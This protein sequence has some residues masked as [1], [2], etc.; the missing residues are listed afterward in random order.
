MRIPLAR[1]G[2]PFI[3]AS[4]FVTI[5]FTITGLRVISYLSLALTTFI[6]AFFRDP[7]REIPEDGIVSPADG[8]VIKVERCREGRILKAEAQKVSIFMSLFDVHVNRIPYSGKVSRISYNPG[9]FFS[10][11]LDKASLENEQNMT[12]IESAN[13]KRIVVNQIAGLIARRIVCYLREGDEVKKG[14]RFGMIIFGSR[15]DVYLP[16]SCRLVVQV[17]DRVKAGS[18]ILGYW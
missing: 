5:I 14:E 13:G 16:L 10:A 2:Y 15:L 18:S 17:G 9:R 7:E 1:K 11:N 8:K 4:I 6:I 3:L 12:L